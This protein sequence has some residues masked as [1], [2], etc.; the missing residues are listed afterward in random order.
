L[1]DEVP[2]VELTVLWPFVREECL[3][4]WEHFHSHVSSFAKEGAFF[5]D[6]VVRP[7]KQLNNGSFLS[8]LVVI[9]LLYLR[10]LPHEVLLFHGNCIFLVVTINSFYFKG[11]RVSDT[12]IGWERSGVGESGVVPVVLE[13]GDAVVLSA[14][15]ID[16][17]R[18]SV[19]SV[20]HFVVAHNSS[21]ALVFWLVHM[22][23]WAI[24]EESLEGSL[25]PVV[26]ISG[27]LSIFA[28][29]VPIEIVAVI[30]WWHDL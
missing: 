12:C 29:S 7:S 21:E 25:R 5:L 10:E 14:N 27:L 9:G 28:A 6:V 22:S 8:I 19:S 3:L 13:L 23:I 15:G 17:S 24:L 16:S 20:R 4:R 1:I 18:F 11:N 26:R 30:L 2:W